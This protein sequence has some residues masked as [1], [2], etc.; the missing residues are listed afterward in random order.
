[1]FGLSEILIIFV[2]G[3]V[4]TGVV[5]LGV[6]QAREDAKKRIGADIDPS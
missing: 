2:F 5:Y 4:V 3:L 1:M 6:L